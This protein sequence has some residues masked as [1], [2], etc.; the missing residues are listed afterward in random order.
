MVT[1]LPALVGQNIELV[2]LKG[3]AGRDRYNGGKKQKSDQE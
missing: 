2:S 1:D 3:T